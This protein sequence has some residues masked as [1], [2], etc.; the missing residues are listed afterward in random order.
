AFLLVLMAFSTIA[1]GPEAPSCV[2]SLG[3]GERQFNLITLSCGNA[4]ARL[5]CQATASITGLYVYCP[6]RRD[7]TSDAT[8]TAN[9]PTIA[10]SV[11]AGAF[12]SGRIGDTYIQASWQGIGSYPQ[13]VS[14]FMNGPPLPTYE[15]S[16]NVFETLS[17]G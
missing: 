14:V 4:G 6:M 3:R 1:C 11:G 15:I 10:K 13:P 17:S 5:V 12:E 9:D 8:W 2:D 16:G 7:I